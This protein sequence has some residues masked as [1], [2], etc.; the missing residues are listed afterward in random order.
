MEFLVLKLP[1]SYKYYSFKE[2]FEMT[3]V[4]NN[5]FLER[6][7]KLIEYSKNNGSRLYSEE[8]LT[9]SVGMHTIGERGTYII[10]HSKKCYC[11][12]YG[13]TKEDGM[14]YT[15]AIS[16]NFIIDGKE[17]HGDYSIDGTH[18][19]CHFHS[20]NRNDKTYYTYDD[21]LYILGSSI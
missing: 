21:I 16:M 20:G 10:E 12:V 7:A 9:C 1:Y 18:D 4:T 2:I 17:Y 6:I 13:D 8:F 14:V 11:R 3:D 5:G 19:I 15:N